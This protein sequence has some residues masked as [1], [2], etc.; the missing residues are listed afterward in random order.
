[1]ASA[2]SEARRAAK[3]LQQFGGFHFVGTIYGSHLFP[4]Q[5]CHA[6]RAV[7]AA[8]RL[9]G[10][11]LCLG[12]LDCSAQRHGVTSPASIFYGDGYVVVKVQHIPD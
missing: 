2:F 9:R 1:M 8:L 5:V 10:V 4:V 12:T 3:L 7:P 11:C 6:P